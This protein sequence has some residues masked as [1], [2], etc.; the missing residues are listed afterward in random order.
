MTASKDSVVS[1]FGQPCE[2][3]I[4]RLSTNL[5]STVVVLF[6]TIHISWRIP[7]SLNYAGLPIDYPHSTLKYQALHAAVEFGHL[8]CARLLVELGAKVLPGTS[9]ARAPMAVLL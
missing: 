9:R 3:D 7:Y 1:V 4:V 8:D 6:T 2:C 5:P